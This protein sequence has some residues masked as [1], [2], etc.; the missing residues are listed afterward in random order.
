MWTGFRPKT[1]GTA[2][3]PG[4]RSIVSC[5]LLRQQL[6]C[7]VSVRLEQL[8]RIRQHPRQVLVRVRAVF[9]CSLY[10]AVDYGAALRSV[11]RVGEQEILAPYD[12]RLDAPLGKVVAYL[13]PP[14]LEVTYEVLP[15][16]P[17]IVQGLTQS[18]LWRRALRLCP[19]QKR[20][21]NRLRLFGAAALLC[22][23]IANLLS[24]LLS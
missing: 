9:L 5:V 16:R 8:R 24:R 17:Q 23:R 22:L 1:A 11:R 21:Q 19:C 4:C 7:P 2:V 3:S 6:C 12:E 18:G 10:E 14:V 20:V 15:L 13:Q